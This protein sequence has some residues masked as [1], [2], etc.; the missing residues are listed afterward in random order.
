MVGATK[1]NIVKIAICIMFKQFTIA[2]LFTY[3]LNFIAYAFMHKLFSNYMFENSISSLIITVSI[4]FI[5][6]LSIL[7]IPIYKLVN[8]EINNNIR[9]I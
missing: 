5:L 9:G 4:L 8:K 2:L 3:G 7:F 1:F 6:C